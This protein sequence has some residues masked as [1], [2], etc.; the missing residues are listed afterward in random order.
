MHRGEVEIQISTFVCMWFWVTEHM[1]PTY[2]P[3]ALLPECG[4]GGARLRYYPSIQWECGWQTSRQVYTRGGKAWTGIQEPWYPIWPC[5]L[6]VC[7]HSC[8]SPM[9]E[10]AIIGHPEGISSDPHEWQSSWPPALCM[11]KGVHV[12]T[13]AQSCL[14]L[15]SALD[16]SPPDSSVFRIFQAKNT[17]VGCY[18][19]LQRIFL[20]KGLN[21]HLLSPALAGR[22]FTTEATWEA[23]MEGG[24]CRKQQPWAF[25]WN[26]SEKL[27]LSSTSWIRFQ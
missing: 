26:P 19:L 11:E 4:M 18:F 22:F 6:I 23:R 12:C 21:P 15:C 16:C 13:H 3:W 7:L 27:T 2:I 24:G 14:T 10:G 17:G 5:P 9:E 25:K 8:S 20:S 1:W